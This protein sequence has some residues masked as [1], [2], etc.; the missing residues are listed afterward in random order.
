MPGIKLVRFGL[1]LLLLVGCAGRLP[2]PQDF[3][4]HS[5]DDPYFNLH[6]RLDREDGVVKVVG[7]VE[8]ARVDGVYS[9]FLQLRELDAQGNIVNTASGRTY[10]APIFQWSWQPFSLR[11][12]PINPED[13]FELKVLTFDWEGA[14]MR[15]SRN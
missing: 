8:A 11:L 12:R 13:R 14:T 6:W 15:G 5:T 3:P 9:V 10:G 7:L 4:L 2:R 1:A